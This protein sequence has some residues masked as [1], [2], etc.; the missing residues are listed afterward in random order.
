MDKLFLD[1]NILLDVLEQR[2]PWY[3][4]SSE[5][6]SQVRRGR[7]K[8]AITALSLSDIA[9]LSAH[10]VDAT[11][12]SCLP[13]ME[14]GFQFEAARKWKATH[15]LTRNLKDFPDNANMKIQDPAGYLRDSKHR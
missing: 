8:G 5:C 11:F 13:D 10:A 7:S 6:L 3:P 9:P 1:T 12:S 15:F 2:S 4:E 14:D